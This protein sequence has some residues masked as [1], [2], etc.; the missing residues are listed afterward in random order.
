MGDR[1]ES[2]NTGAGKPSITA[3]WLNCPC[4]CQ[5]R[6]PFIDDPR[7]IRYRPMPPAVDWPH[8]DTSE[9]GLVAHERASCK[10]C[11]AAAS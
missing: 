4:G 1:A 7:C 11:Q 8:Y 9:L 6:L 10:H 5:T 2:K 3:R